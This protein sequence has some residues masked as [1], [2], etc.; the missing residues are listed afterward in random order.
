MR[1]EV[2]HEM[3]NGRGRNWAEEVGN[4]PGGWDD[5]HQATVRHGQGIHSLPTS[6][7]R[8]WRITGPGVE[9]RMLHLQGLRTRPP[10]GYCAGCSSDNRRR[11]ARIRKVRTSSSM[12]AC[13]GD[14][15]NRKRSKQKVMNGHSRERTKIRGD[16][17]KRNHQRGEG[18]RRGIPELP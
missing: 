12:K 6:R 13:N 7:E 1:S 5:I 14:P 10:T 3:S 17:L 2:K 15:L 8:Q 11:T 18:A 4:G 16:A 9:I